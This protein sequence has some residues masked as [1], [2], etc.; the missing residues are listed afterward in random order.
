MEKQMYPVILYEKLY[1]DLEARPDT[2][3]PGLN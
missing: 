3:C 1:K 2:N